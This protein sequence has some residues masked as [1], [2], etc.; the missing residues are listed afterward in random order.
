MSFAANILETA[1][2][3]VV[4]SL[5]PLLLPVVGGDTDAARAAVLEL[6]VD[7]RPRTAQELILAG[8]AVGHAI[9]GL[10]ML[11]QSA[12]PGIADDK[13]DSAL[14]WACSLTRSGHQAQRK[15][16]ALRRPR[17][18]V[19]RGEAVP[20]EVADPNVVDNT[21]RDIAHAAVTQPEPTTPPAPTDTAP[22]DIAQAEAKL[23]SAEKLLSLMQAH[24]KGAP[25]PHTK[26]AQQIQAQTRVVATARLTLEQARRQAA[27]TEPQ[28]EPMQVAA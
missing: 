22:T 20:E 9:K 12:E 10:Q 26:A 27:Q 7:H 23:K 25:P 17:R 14:K 24:H 28:T 1:V 21:P 4:L 19:P 3:L 16:E 11:A 18:M 2:N 15:L 6:L 5:L 8:Q 13:R